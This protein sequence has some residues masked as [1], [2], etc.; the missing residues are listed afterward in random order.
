[1]AWNPKSLLGRIIDTLDASERWYQEEITDVDTLSKQKTEGE[2]DDNTCVSE[3]E[4]DKR[5]NVHVAVEV[6]EVWVDFC[7][8]KECRSARYRE[9]MLC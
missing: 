9:Y 1:M 5:D 3:A 7:D 2:S 4:D 8:Y 6:W